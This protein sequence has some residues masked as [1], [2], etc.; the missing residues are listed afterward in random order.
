MCPDL[1]LFKWYWGVISGVSDLSLLDSMAQGKSL[2]VPQSLCVLWLS[3]T[4]AQAS[5]SGRILE[6]IRSVVVS[7][8]LAYSLLLPS[9]CSYGMTGIRTFDVQLR[10]STTVLHTHSK[11]GFNKLYNLQHR[12]N[13]QSVFVLLAR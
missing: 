8:P 2:S 13:Q 5:H 9:G 10:C 4:V 6:S 3:S 11:S 1:L 7:W 12:S